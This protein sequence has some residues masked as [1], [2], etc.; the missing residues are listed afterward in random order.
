VRRSVV[1]RE[2]D[3]LAVEALEGQVEVERGRVLE[4]ELAYGFEP[5]AALDVDDAHH[6]R[7]SSMR[8]PIVRPR[9][10]AS[11]VA[12]YRNTSRTFR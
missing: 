5:W 12:D 1:P 9:H 10:T 2:G 3:Q 11:P 8:P 4:E 6:G 7:K